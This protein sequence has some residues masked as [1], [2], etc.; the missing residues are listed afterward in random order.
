MRVN[1]T[2]GIIG[3]G[4]MGT[5]LSERL[6]AA[7]VPVLGFDIEPARCEKLKAL[8]GLVATSVHE[9]ADRSRAIIIAVY[10]GEQVETLFGELGSGAGSAYPTVV[11]TTTCAPDE[12]A[13]LA[14]GA[15]ALG[16]PFVEAPISGTSAELREGAATAL[17]AGETGV[18]D[19]IGTLLRIICPRCMC[20]GQIGNASRVKLAINLILQNNRAALAEGIVFAECLGLDGQTFL[21]AARESAAY[22]RVMDSKGDKMLARDFQPQSHLSQTLKDAELILKEAQRQDLHLPMTL[23]QASLLR[24]AIALKGP[25]SDSAAVIEAIRRRAASSEVSQ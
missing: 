12:I 10:S 8:G 19:A 9:L 1:G 15:T 11:C 23:T 17:V 25:D 6:I 4:L 3:L 22:S 24:T 13:R 21:K 20:V 7:T 18:I 2:V 16:I 5:A 14:Q